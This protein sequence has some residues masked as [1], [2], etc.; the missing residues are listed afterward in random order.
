MAG[1][2]F[3][4]WLIGLAV[5]TASYVPQIRSSWQDGREISQ[6][7]WWLWLWTEAASVGFAACTGAWAWVVASG[8]GMIAIMLVL[9]GAIR[10]HPPARWPLRFLVPAALA[11][12][13]PALLPGG[14]ALAAW[15]VTLAVAEGVSLV[16]Y[17]PQV[18]LAWHSGMAASRRRAAPWWI[19][20]L[21]AALQVGYALFVAHD[22]VW[23]LL[24][25]A[26]IACAIL[27]AL[28][29]SLTPNQRSQWSARLRSAAAV[30]SYGSFVRVACQPLEATGLTAP[31]AGATTQTRSLS[32][33][34]LLAA[35]F[36]L[37]AARR[38]A[39]YGSGVVPP[40]TAMTLSAG[41]GPAVRHGPWLRGVRWTAGMTAWRMRRRS[42]AGP[43]WV[44]D[45]VAFPAAV[46]GA[47]PAPHH[48]TPSA[49]LR[50][51][52][53]TSEPF[54]THVNAFSSAGGRGGPFWKVDHTGRPGGKR[55]FV[56]PSQ[57]YGMMPH[58]SSAVAHWTLSMGGTP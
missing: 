17:I 46:T 50:V 40:N 15:S 12:L 29:L 2:W 51:N 34:H 42:A 4:A 10:N 18:R 14:I 56:R 13:I 53:L 35:R 33:V 11:L 52:P 28:P 47:I 54:M 25:T 55:P 23:A 45:R 1:I 37:P 16:A 38:I 3:I 36:P 22:T 32:T 9:V 58:P 26:H 27:V 48:E 21:A 19:G 24:L 44:M 5:V 39:W 41:V 49:G 7:A 43:T 30:L 31:M 6:S 20:V 8:L 57:R